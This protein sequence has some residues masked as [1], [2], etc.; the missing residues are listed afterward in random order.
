MA[1]G[2]TP[3]KQH[4]ST[5]IAAIL[6]GWPLAV[7]LVGSTPPGKVMT[8]PIGPATCRQDL[9]D[10]RWGDGRAGSVCTALLARPIQLAGRRLP[11]GS[12]LTGVANQDGSATFEWLVLPSGE[13]QEITPITLRPGAPAP[14]REFW[15]QCAAV[16]SRASAEQ[17]VDDLSQVL[18]EVPAIQEA[19]RPG[20][21]ARITFRLRLGPF[22]T[23]DAALARL[24]GLSARFSQRHLKPIIV[25]SAP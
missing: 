9:R 21:E 10:I 22:L 11:L 20:E 7:C 8:L 12:R 17:L 23:R 1:T 2:I 13:A 14:T 16:P 25:M 6:M 15:I 24:K 18:E 4:G 5:V 3:R 19:L